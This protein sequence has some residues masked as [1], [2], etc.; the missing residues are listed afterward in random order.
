M[1]QVEPLS[2]HLLPSMYLLETAVLGKL[3][4]HGGTMDGGK[5]LLSTKIHLGTFKYTSQVFPFEDH[6]STKFS[7]FSVRS[8]AFLELAL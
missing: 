6:L 1:W 7:R 2:G 5:E 4:M 3:W 8:V